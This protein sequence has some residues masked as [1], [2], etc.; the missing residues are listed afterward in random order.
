MGVQNV[1]LSY[2]ALSKR[3]KFPNPGLLNGIFPS[4]RIFLLNTGGY[5]IS[6]DD[7]A[8]TEEDIYELANRYMAF[9]SDNL[10]YI[11]LLNSITRR[12]APSLSRSGTTRRPCRPPRPGSVPVSWWTRSRRNRQPARPDGLVRGGRLHSL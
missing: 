11:D 6:K 12:V 4:S 7:S 10:A 9:V 1:S 5:A 2:S 8:L 3:V